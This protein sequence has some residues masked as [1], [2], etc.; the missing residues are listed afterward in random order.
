MYEIGPGRGALTRHLTPRCE[1][2]VAVEL[3]H[4]LIAPLRVSFP[5]IE[6]IEA[7]VRDFPFGGECV[8]CG[9]LPYYITSPIVE[10]A[11]AVAGLKRAVF[12]VQREVALRLAAGP[13]SRDYGY[14]SVV[15]Q[16]VGAVEY[17]FTVAPGAFAPP[18]KVDSAVVRITPRAGAV[19]S[20]AL[21]RFVGRCF[22]QKRKTLRNNLATLYPAI[23]GRPEAGLR[24]E[25][26]PVEEF[27]RLLA[28]LV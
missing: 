20:P 15:T 9:N 26:L 5:S 4:G 19:V 28:A 21:R 25:Q 3:D 18:P 7:D 27:P 2:L 11:L 22:L 14:L 6:V 10:R 12:L 13:G 8:I 23:E 17:L 1:R 16:L 24:A